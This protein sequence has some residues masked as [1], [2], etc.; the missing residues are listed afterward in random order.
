M[1]A[2]KTAEKFRLTPEERR[3]LKS[4]SPERSVQRLKL[5]A[6]LKL[7]DKHTYRLRRDGISHPAGRVQ[8]LEEMGYVINS[9]RITAVDEHGYVHP[10]VALYELVSVP[11][12]GAK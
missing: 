6:L 3:A 7:G 8:D 12:G 11:E 2:R 9:H 5:V 10:G 1:S 4:D